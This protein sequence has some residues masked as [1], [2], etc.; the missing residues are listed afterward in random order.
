MIDIK[1]DYIH[2]RAAIDMFKYEGIHEECFSII[3]EGV[4]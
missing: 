1:K 3:K 4:S 2:S